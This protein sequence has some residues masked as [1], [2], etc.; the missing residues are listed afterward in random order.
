[1]I[2]EKKKFTKSPKKNKGDLVRG[3]RIEQWERC[4]AKAQQQLI[5]LAICNL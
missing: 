5:E 3:E 2:G 1:V 4:K